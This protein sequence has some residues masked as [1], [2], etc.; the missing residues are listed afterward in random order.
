MDEEELAGGVNVVRRVGQTVVRSAGPHSATVHRLLQHVRNR[1]FDRGPEPLGLDQASGTETL[2][3]LPGEVTNYP[4]S[5]TFRTEGVLVQAAKML[6][7]YHDATTDSL[8]FSISTP[9]TQDHGSWTS[10][11]P[12]T[13]GCR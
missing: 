4:V 2:S 8:V 12:S 5:D 10:G 13:A 11:M 6:R 3:F 7:A 9:L 1:G